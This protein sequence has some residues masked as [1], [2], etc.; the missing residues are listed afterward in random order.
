MIYRIN[1][2]CFSKSKVLVKDNLL[3]FYEVGTHSLNIGYM[4]FML[5]RVQTH[6]FSS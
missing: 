4:K 2:N 1:K 6:L 5:Q 3:V